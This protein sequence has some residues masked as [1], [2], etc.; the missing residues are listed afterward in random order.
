M[1]STILLVTSTALTLIQDFAPLVNDASTVG[2]IISALETYLPVVAQEASDLIQPIK[3]IIA[4]LSANPATTADQLAALQALDQQAD[5]AFDAAA[6][7]Y[8][9]AHPDPGTSGA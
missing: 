5:A 6:A 8:E 9:A 3:N 4:A 2:K 7:A 1:N